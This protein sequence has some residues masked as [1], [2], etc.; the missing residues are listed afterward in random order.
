MTDIRMGHVYTMIEGK[1]VYME[2]MIIEGELGRKLRPDERVRHKN[3]NAY[4]NRR[5]NL[6]IIT[7]ET[8]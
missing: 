4:D 3:G 8:A 6:E 7:E 1:R 2:D 5:S